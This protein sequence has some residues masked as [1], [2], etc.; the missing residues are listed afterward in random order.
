MVVC[1]GGGAGEEV[2]DSEAD[3]CLPLGCGGK[4]WR[5]EMGELR[6]VLGPESRPPSTFCAQG[7][8]LD[9]DVN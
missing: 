5:E 4:V 6:L 3:P 9:G 2:T 8:L 1:S 7:S